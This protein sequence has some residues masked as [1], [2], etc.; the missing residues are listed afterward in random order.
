MLDLLISYI[1][2]LILAIVY[3][4]KCFA[5]NPPDPPMY[6][7]QHTD[8]EDEDDILFLIQDKNK[9]PKY[10]IIEFMLLDYKF[11]KLIYNKK[12]EELPLLLLIPP[13]HIPVCIIYSHGNSGDL[14]GCI[15]EYYDIAM[16]TNCL[17]VSFEYPGYGDCA[18]QPLRE[19]LFYRNLKMT[20]YFVR[21]ILD[22]KPSQI[23]L[24]GFSMG[25]GIVFD[26]ACNKEYP[27][28]GMILQSPFLSIIRTLYNI[29]KT[30]YFD[31]FNNCDKAKFLKTKTFFIHGTK[32]NVVPFIHGKILAKLIPQ[33][34]YYG[35]YKVDNANHNNLFKIGKEKVF[36]KIRDFIKDCTGF[37]SDF[38]RDNM[39]DEKTSS[40]NNKTNSDIII[41]ND[42]KTN[43]K[44]SI[45]NEEYINNSIN[46][47]NATDR[48]SNLKFPTS[49]INE[50]NPIMVNQIINNKN[51]LIIIYKIINSYLL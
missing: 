47:L 1:N 27:T 20:Y 34:Y 45:K 39:T 10:K 48:T 5:F 33:Q 15:L 24:Y 40:S 35:F 49:L 13:A 50:N 28:A 31:F 17:V 43:S 16:N 3:I 46:K 51:L 30:M 37:Y 44:N 9:K 21:K 4:V 41:N 19:S 29:K 26:L 23:I 14:G 38:N 2:F 22:Y 6:I 18:N 12:N 7:S 25:T 11:I 32:D 42:S 8:K 36:A